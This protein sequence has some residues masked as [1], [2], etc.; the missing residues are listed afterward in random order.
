MYTTHPFHKHKKPKKYY[1]SIY[2]QICPAI[3]LMLN[4]AV[5]RIAINK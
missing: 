1:S 2:L 5:S 4:K 3:P